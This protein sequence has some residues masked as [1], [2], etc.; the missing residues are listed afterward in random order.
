VPLCKVS[1]EI[2]E[3]Q[4]KNAE[5]SEGHTQSVAEPGLNS[6]VPGLWP[7]AQASHTQLY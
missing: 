6:E 1:V 3:E 2:G 5:A 4:Q 7:E